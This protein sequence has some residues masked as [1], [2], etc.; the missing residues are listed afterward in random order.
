MI[1]RLTDW[2]GRLSLRERLLIVTLVT[3]VLPPFVYFSVLVPLHDRRVSA[4]ATL[5]SAQN[6]AIWAQDRLAEYARLEQGDAPGPAPSPIGLSGVE[7]LLIDAGLRLNTLVTS[8]PDSESFELAFTGVQFEQLM[9]WLEQLEQKA[10]YRI[11]LLRINATEIPGLV[12]A[13][14]LSD[15]AR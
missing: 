2:L 8:S 14:V 5:Q 1:A 12:D 15:A 11:A 9:S 4:A 7:T 10:G 3:V 6:D 13:T